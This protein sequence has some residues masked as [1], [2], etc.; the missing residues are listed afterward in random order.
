[1]H[2]LSLKFDVKLE[3]R[4]LGNYR[5]IISIRNIDYCLEASQGFGYNPLYYKIFQFAK[6][7]TKG[8]V[9]ECPYKPGRMH[10]NLTEEASSKIEEMANYNNG[11]IPSGDY[12]ASVRIY[13][14]KDYATLSGYITLKFIDGGPEF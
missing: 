12:I 1:M 5:D 9:H 3:Y 4:A 2:L 14:G 11:F 13:D 8:M 10:F 6:E 7:Y